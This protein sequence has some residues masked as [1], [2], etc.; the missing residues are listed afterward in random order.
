MVPGSPV[1]VLVWELRLL[2]LHISPAGNSTKEGAGVRNTL[3][4]ILVI[5]WSAVFGA[6]FLSLVSPRAAAILLL[7]L[8]PV[9]QAIRV[10]MVAL[11]LV[12][13]ATGISWIYRKGV[14]AHEADKMNNENPLTPQNDPQGH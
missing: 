12:S 11:M 14:G 10:F 2:L 5:C 13:I 7:S 1:W 3:G 4:R 8:L 9:I 6:L